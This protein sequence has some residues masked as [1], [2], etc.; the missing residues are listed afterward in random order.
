VTVHEGGYNAVRTSMDLPISKE[1]IRVV[2]SA[3]GPTVKVPTMG[4]SVPLEMIE[5]ALGTRT[6]TIPIAN[7]DN[8]QHSFNENIR[9]QN[10]WDGIDLMAALIT[11]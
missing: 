5:R 2:E 8:N 3:R 7:H 6:I 11:M 9:V 4:G 10:L 1:V